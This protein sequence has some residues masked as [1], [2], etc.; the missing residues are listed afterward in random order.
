MTSLILK[1][2]FSLFTMQPETPATSSFGLGEAMLLLNR[3]TGAILGSIGVMVL[4]ANVLLGCMLLTLGPD[5]TIELLV[6]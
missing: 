4:V 5:F 2:E 6:Q 3:I 1:P